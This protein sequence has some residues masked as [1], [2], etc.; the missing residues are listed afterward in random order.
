MNKDG[1]TSN[2]ELYPDLDSEM[3]L[4]PFM[5]QELTARWLVSVSTSKWNPTEQQLNL[6]SIRTRLFSPGSSY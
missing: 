2:T 1:D 5:L 4:T 6:T 3:V